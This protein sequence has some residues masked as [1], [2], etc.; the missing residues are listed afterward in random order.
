M[1]LVILYQTNHK[2]KNFDVNINVDKVEA[3]NNNFADDEEQ[4]PTPDSLVLE[5]FLINLIGLSV[6]NTY[7]FK[8]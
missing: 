3:N 1:V 8:F 2:I 7:L 5:V 6:E 4:Y